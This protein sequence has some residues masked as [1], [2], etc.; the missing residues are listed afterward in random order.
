LLGAGLA[1]RMHPDRP[2][3]PAEGSQRQVRVN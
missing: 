3:E 1:F 2:F